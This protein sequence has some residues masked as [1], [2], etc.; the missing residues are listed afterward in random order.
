MTLRLNHYAGAQVTF[1]NEI[2]GTAEDAIKKANES[3][4]Q[5]H[6]GHL[7]QILSYA[8]LAVLSIATAGAAYV[9]A[10]TINYVC[11][12][13]FFFSTKVNTDSINKVNELQASVEELIGSPL[14]V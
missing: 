13:Q 4:L 3:E 12:G 6:R 11:N 2:K 14:T 7:K 5:I 8:G 9:V 10:G 1:M